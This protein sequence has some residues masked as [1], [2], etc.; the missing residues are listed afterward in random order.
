MKRTIVLLSLLLTSLSGFS[1]GF[2]TG[3]NYISVGYGLEFANSANSNTS[4]GGTQIK[5]D[6][7]TFGP[8]WLKYEHAITDNIGIGTDFGYTKVSS[9]TTMTS[10]DYNGDDT[11][12]VF[13]TEVSA[14]LIAAKGYYHFILNN[15]KLD[16]YLS[17]GI[18]VGIFSAKVDFGDE[19]D[20]AGMPAMA[21]DGSAVVYYPAVGARYLFSENFGAFL[22]LGFGSSAGGSGSGAFSQLGLS[23]SFGG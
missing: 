6:N 5:T 20:D 21:V 16:P 10:T 22:E 15:E 23:F 8:L 3:K 13:K 2:T 14:I 17:L 7:S 1:Q 19:F 9:K 4:M 12:T 11:E 18:G